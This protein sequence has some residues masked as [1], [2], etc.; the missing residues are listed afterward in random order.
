MIL[1]GLSG[2]LDQTIHTI[3]ALTKLHGERELGTWVVGRES[4]A[5]ILGTVSRPIPQRVATDI[6]QGRH[7][8]EMPLEHFGETCAVLPIG[9]EAK[10][11]TKGLRW[12]FGPG[13]CTLSLAA[14]QC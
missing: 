10:V 11:T 8:I 13:L 9:E 2:R 4:V 6:H 12:D 5:C 14:A 7:T 3:H 1:G